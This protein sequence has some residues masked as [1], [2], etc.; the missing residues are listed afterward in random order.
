MGFNFDFD[1]FYD[2]VR[3]HI[4][5]ERNVMDK[6][7]LRYLFIEAHPKY[8]EINGMPYIDVLYKSADTKGNSLTPTRICSKITLSS[9]FP[10]IKFTLFSHFSKILAQKSEFFYYKTIATPNPLA[11][12]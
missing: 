7:L 4:M 3:M 11:F 10:A 2:K 5:A 1:K 9:D 6:G 8:R 12:F